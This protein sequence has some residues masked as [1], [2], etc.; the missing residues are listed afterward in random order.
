MDLNENSS[1]PLY[2]QV[3]NIILSEIQTGHWKAGEQLKPELELSEQYGV[4]RVTVR[5]ALDEL[6]NEGYLIKRQGKGTFVNRPKLQRKID[7]VTSFSMAC[8]YNQM[9]PSSVVV[10]TEVL[11]QGYDQEIEEFLALSK[12]DKILYVQRIRMADEEPVM[13]ENNYYSWNRYKGLLD[14]DLTESVYGLLIYKYHVLPFGDANNTLEIVCANKEQAALLGV[15]VGEPLFFMN[16]GVCEP[17]KTPIHFGRQYIIG[18]RYKFTIK[19]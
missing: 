2:G 6:V 18:S 8:K 10:K 13:L 15:S 12:K 17:D 7:Y 4:S 16:G 14:E 5:K 9:K 11:E 19:A 3:K 1:M